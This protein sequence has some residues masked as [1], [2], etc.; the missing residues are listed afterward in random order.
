MILVMHTS[1]DSESKL[2]WWIRLVSMGASV[3]SQLYCMK[4]KQG[5]L[6]SEEDNLTITDFLILS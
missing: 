1:Q 2:T 6:H 4:Q 5:I 3:F